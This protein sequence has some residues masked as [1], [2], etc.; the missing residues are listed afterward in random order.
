MTYNIMA[1]KQ[2]HILVIRLSA[3]GDVAMSVP[4]LRAFLQQHPNI[5]LTVLTRA[6]FKPFFRDLKNVTVFSPDLTGK[7]KGFFGLY[8]LSRALKNLGIDK[9]ADLHNVL[10][11]KILKFFSSEELSSNWIKVEVKRKL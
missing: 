7:H 10:R 4:V 11:T 8:R 5:K 3:M 9:V 1:V 6:F 2:K